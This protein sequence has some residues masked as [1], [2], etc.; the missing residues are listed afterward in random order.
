MP[1][2]EVRQPHP[3]WTSEWWKKKQAGFGRLGDPFRQ[4]GTTLSAYQ[5]GLRQIGGLAGYFTGGNKPQPPSWA[6]TPGM[7]AFGAWGLPSQP[8]WQDYSGLFAKQLGAQA[9]V[10]TAI[11]QYGRWLGM[12]PTQIEDAIADAEMAGN[13]GQLY[14]Q[15]K[16]QYEY[17]QKRQ[18]EEMISQPKF[19]GTGGQLYQSEAAMNMAQ[20]RENTFGGRMAVGRTAW[21]WAINRSEVEDVLYNI[22]DLEGS[23]EL[24][25]IVKAEYN[26]I[27][28]SLEVGAGTGLAEGPHA[29]GGEYPNVYT[30]G[31]A[32]PPAGTSLSYLGRLPGIESFDEPYSH[33]YEFASNW[34]MEMPEYQQLAQMLTEKRLKEY[35][36]IYPI[37][38]QY[39]QAVISGEILG[40][41]PSQ[42]MG[43]EREGDSRKLEAMS[44]KGEERPYKQKLYLSF[45]QWMESTP[46]VQDYFRIKEQEKRD[47]AT[48]IERL[49]KP[50]KWAVAQQ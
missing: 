9:N 1:D 25:D 8:T 10:R 26:R 47:E 37:Y 21:Q 16:E 23:G 4:L 31:G 18:Q 46:E 33:P 38:E 6:Q 42:G 35:P 5:Q 27:L 39:R 30:P 17:P 13:L 24:L 19:G 22:G 3:F 29:Y 36:T 28:A 48:Y 20:Y 43:A 34:I 50:P 2:G 49:Q 44:F 14:T 40:I 45:D 32:P 15:L 7:G 12:S 41:M 11:Q